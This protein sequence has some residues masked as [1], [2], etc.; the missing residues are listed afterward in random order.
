MGLRE[1]S[2]DVCLRDV[3]LERAVVPL[4]RTR[5]RRRHGRRATACNASLLF[6]LAMPPYA[7]CVPWAHRAQCILTQSG[8]ATDTI[9]MK[10]NG[11]LAT[12]L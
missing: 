6:C 7:I 1:A 10:S 12:T 8:L 4:N 5:E 11:L 9:T 2:G 3:L